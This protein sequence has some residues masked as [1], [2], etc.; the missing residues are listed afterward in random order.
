MWRRVGVRADC[1]VV[2][3]GLMGRDRDGQLAVMGEQEVDALHAMR[4]VAFA[5]VGNDTGWG[6]DGTEAHRCVDRRSQLAAVSAGG[7]RPGVQHDDG[8][9]APVFGPETTINHP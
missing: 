8:T 3:G 1:Y 5:Q 9:E 6:D 4:V 2:A 7:L